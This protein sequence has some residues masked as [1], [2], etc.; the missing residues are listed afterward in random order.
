MVDVVFVVAL[1]YWIAGGL[2]AAAMYGSS[3]AQTAGMALVAGLAWPLVALWLVVSG[4]RDW[5][6]VARKN[7]PERRKSQ[8]PETF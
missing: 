4:V 6:K 7:L 3:K 8:K 2:T 1:V 5:V